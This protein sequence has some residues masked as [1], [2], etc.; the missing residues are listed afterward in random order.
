MNGLERRRAMMA[1]QDIDT[2]QLANIGTEDCVVTTNNVTDNLYY[3]IDGAFVKWNTTTAEDVTTRDA[4]TIPSGKVLYIYSKSSSTTIAKF[5]R[6]Y[7]NGS[8]I[9]LR[10]TLKALRTTLSI[11]IFSHLFNGCMNL[12]SINSNKLIPWMHIPNTALRDFASSS[13]LM[14]V[15]T[16]LFSNITSSD[17]FGLAHFFNSC[18]QL[19]KGPIVPICDNSSLDS[20]FRNCNKM[21]YIE[22]T[23]TEWG[24]PNVWVQSVASSGIFVKPSSLPEEYGN[25]RIPSGWTVINKD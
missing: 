25:N 3:K 12:V 11:A 19:S 10:G 16:D 14:S 17:A 20:H 24:T 22:V 6:F 4:V 15:N 7:L 5:G 21:N 8:E 2:L 23:F 18:E 1:A 13:G 9:E